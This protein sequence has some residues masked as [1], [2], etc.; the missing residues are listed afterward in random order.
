MFEGPPAVAHGGYTGGM[1]ARYLPADAEVTLRKPV[2]VGASLR[3]EPRDGG[4]VLYDGPTVVAEAARSQLVSHAP[5]PP[6]FAE[7][8][9]ASAAFPGF[10]AHPFPPCA[11]CGPE[12]ADA[13]AF[14]LFPGPVA[15]RDLLAAVWYP[16][17]AA[18]AGGA[19]RPEFAWAAL[20]CPAGWAALWFGRVDGA[21]VLGR[22]ATRLDEPVPAHDAHILVGWLEGV[23]G[24]K[25]FAGSALY[26]R[27][28]ALQGFSRQT[29]IM[30]AG[31][32]ARQ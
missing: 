5:K 6:A 19:L 30:V 26:S 16:T 10:A 29:W 14:R 31:T 2:R 3:L 13:G 4:V 25:L 1:L 7:A 23:S 20:D 17:S 21:A 9:A 18:L 11:V 24:R 8:L 28:G 12:R 32:G 22:M 27:S 15:G